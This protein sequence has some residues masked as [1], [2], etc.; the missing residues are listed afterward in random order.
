MLIIII[1]LQLI[2]MRPISLFGWLLLAWFPLLTMAQDESFAA[3]FYFEKA[4]Y[5]S[6]TSEEGAFEEL[7]AYSK[8]HPEKAIILQGHSDNRGNPKNNIILSRARAN[9][10]VQ[11]LLQAGVAMERLHVKAFGARYPFHSNTYEAGR[12]L[13]RRVEVFLVDEVQVVHFTQAYQNKRLKEKIRPAPEHFIIKNPTK[14]TFWTTSR[15]TKL[16]IPADA[17]EGAGKQKVVLEF[18]EAYSF[19]DMLLSGLS[20]QSKEGLLTTGGMF[21]LTATNSQGELLAM[22]PTKQI[23]VQVPTDSVLP[24]MQLYA[25]DTN[26]VAGTWVN[27]RPLRATAL[28][29]QRLNN[30]QNVLD[31]AGP[32]ALDCPSIEE[33][34]PKDTINREDLL[35]QIAASKK[36]YQAYKIPA[37]EKY[38]TTTIERALDDNQVQQ[39]ILQE[40]H[41]STCTN[42]FCR[43]K[44]GFKKKK[45][46]A[47]AKKKAAEERQAL[48]AQQAVLEQKIVEK[49]RLTQLNQIAIEQAVFYKEQLKKTYETQKG[50][51]DNLHAPLINMQAFE[52]I[53]CSV[54]FP[55][56]PDTL[57]PLANKDRQFALCFYGKRI[58]S[59][60][61]FYREYESLIAPVFYGTTTYAQGQ[62][63]ELL[64][65]YKAKKD[66]DKLQQYFPE[67]E[68]E[69]CQ[70]L[71]KVDNFAAAKR[72][73]RY[74]HYI[75]YSDLN[76]LKREFP[77]REK[78]ISQRLYG[79]ENFGEAQKEQ[80]RQQF[81]AYC[82][83]YDIT[84]LQ[85]EYPKREREACQVMYGVSTFRAAYT[86]KARKAN[87]RDNYYR[88][89]LTNRA[90]GRWMNLDCLFKT[91]QP[92][93]VQTIPLSNSISIFREDYLIYSNTRAIN[94]YPEKKPTQTVFSGVVEGLEHTLVSYYALDDQQ[95]AFATTTFVGER[96]EQPSLVYE[97]LSVEGFVGRLAAIR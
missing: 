43:I 8:E 27:P 63:K 47:A 36:T 34:L 42:L 16:Y 4:T 78:Q 54:N 60:Q 10:L 29:N 40:A 18:R 66:L 25:L 19:A 77:E 33:L 86:A 2:I 20:T 21:E 55:S 97:V 52:Q 26:T 73:Q 88:V 32:V 23:G 7:I 58:D 74:Q 94:G 51:L 6:Y 46:A 50:R 1:T 80:K 87:L 37:K 68:Q 45:L 13:N 5:Q 93:L 39:A 22:S 24:A 64:A 59:L 14:E 28:V 82:N 15:G 38:S 17:F 70:L 92:M 91:R 89:Q 48:Q 44:E 67:L 81:V 69:V 79:V 30:W 11:Q 41:V 12:K 62:R 84:R 9:H 57:H 61:R 72:E 31:C 76:A 75:T 96:K 3:V 90:L 53:A 95:V 49:K 71:Y 35:N 83:N 85:K 65:A 56:M